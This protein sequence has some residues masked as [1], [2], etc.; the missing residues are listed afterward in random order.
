[1]GH[2]KAHAISCEGQKVFGIARRNFLLFPLTFRICVTLIAPMNGNRNFFVM[3]EVGGVLSAVV[4]RNDV[5][6]QLF[7]SIVV[8][9][10]F[11]SNRA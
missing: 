4:I 2:Y 1:M 6:Q 3:W 11:F 5:I 7:L 8:F 9:V 10:S